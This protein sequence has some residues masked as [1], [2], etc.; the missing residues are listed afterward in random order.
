M[1][2]WFLF[3]LVQ[4]LQ[5]RTKKCESYSDHGMKGDVLNCQFVSVFFA[6][7]DAVLLDLGESAFPVMERI[8]ISCS[9]IFVEADTINTFKNRLDKHGI[10]QEVCLIIMQI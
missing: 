4:K 10:D 8:H 6:E 9:G 3:L 1:E 7:S 2:Y 5:K